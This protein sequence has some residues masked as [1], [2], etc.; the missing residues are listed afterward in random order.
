MKLSRVKKL[1]I[2]L[3]GIPCLLFLFVTVYS[4]YTKAWIGAIIFGI[5]FQSEL[6][7]AIKKWRQDE[8]I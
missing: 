7:N 3:Y 8:G 5:L 1:I 4:I 6:R 2:I